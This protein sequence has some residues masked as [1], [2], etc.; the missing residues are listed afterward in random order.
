RTVMGAATAGTLAVFLV[1]FAVGFFDGDLLVLFGAG[2]SAESVTTANTW[3]RLT[4]SLVA[5]VAAGVAGYAY[6][7]RHSGLRWPAYLVAGVA[8]G[9]LV[10]IAEVLTR[11][12][13]ARLFHLVSLVSLDDA[14]VL[15][16]LH[17]ARVSRGLL[18]LFAGGLVAIIL[19]GRTLKPRPAP[20]DAD[21]QQVGRDTGA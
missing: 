19:F 15:G 16:L 12:G 20:A 1:G 17:S 6:L 14:A 18:V 3:V 5:G 9:A 4:T 8:P 10:L 13:G 11:L 7:R 21:A 2:E